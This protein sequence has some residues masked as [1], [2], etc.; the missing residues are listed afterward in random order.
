MQHGRVLIAVNDRGARYPITID[1]L[2][3]QGAK[4]VPDDVITNG[5][6]QLSRRSVAISPDGNTA[7]IGAFGDRQSNDVGAAWVFMRSDGV[8]SQQG[9]KL[10]PTD[11]R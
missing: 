8:W 3:Q 9:P 4:L 11:R 5:G 6:R 7:L 1:P 10:V 2:V